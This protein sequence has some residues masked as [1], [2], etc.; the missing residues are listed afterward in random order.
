M[1]LYLLF[2]FFSL[3]VFLNRSREASK[4]FGYFENIMIL[5]CDLIIL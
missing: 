1:L 3:K 5:N 4:S 2:V